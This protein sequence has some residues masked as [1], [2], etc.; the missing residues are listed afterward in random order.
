MVF[1][2]LK[3]KFYKV[4]LKSKYTDNS[5]NSLYYYKHIRYLLLCVKLLMKD[6]AI[7]HQTFCWV[8]VMIPHGDDRKEFLPIGILGKH[9]LFSS[10]E[11]IR[12]DW[13][14]RNLQ[15]EGVIYPK[16]NIKTEKKK[17]KCAQ[18]SQTSTN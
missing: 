16:G 1:K 9:V 6:Q 10:S 4:S 5:K 12:Y 17:K 3:F 13:V 15:H 14:L 11:I 7:N 8:T 18:S 2:D